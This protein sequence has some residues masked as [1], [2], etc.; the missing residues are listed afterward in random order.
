MNDADGPAGRGLGTRLRHLLELL[1]GDVE[2]TYR[3]AGLAGYR[4]RYTPVVRILTERGEASLKA[5]AAAAG[6]SHSAVSQTV[7]QMARA[8]LVALR[9]GS[10]ARERLASLTPEAR[11]LLPRLQAIWADTDAAAR[12]LEAD[13]HGPVALSTAID[14]A[15][16]ALE[17][18]PFRERIRA[19][20]ARHDRR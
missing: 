13:A 6:T 12:A 10:D 14:A 17:R 11:A 7:A 19:Q 4:P 16:A 1:D 3:D 5:I 8:G 9:P 2:A 15:I 20:R 18:S